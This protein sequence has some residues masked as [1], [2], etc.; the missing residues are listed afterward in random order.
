MLKLEEREIIKN[1]ITKGFDIKLISFELDIPLEEVKKCKLELEVMKKSALDMVNIKGNQNINKLD[2]IR[3]K[4]EE[5][6]FSNVENKANCLRALTDKEND[7]INSTFVELNKLLENINEIT[8]KEKYDR[9]NEIYNRIRMIENYPLTIEQ[10]EKLFSI[11]QTQS[12]SNLMRDRDQKRINKIKRIAVQK[13]ANAIDDIQL[14]TDELEELKKLK[15][16]LTQKMQQNN[17]IAVESIKTKIDAKITKINRQNAI[18][19]VRNNIP[20][21]IDFIIN[22]LAD[23]ELDIKKANEIIDEE[24][25]GR[26]ENEPKNKFSLTEEQERKQIFIQIRN[27]LIE[28]AKKYYIKNPET[29]IMQIHE[30]CGGELEE[31]IRAVAENLINTKDFERA[32]EVCSRFNGKSY[33]SS[34][35]VYIR[36]LRKNIQNAEIADIILKAI[37]MNGTEE[38]QKKCWDILEK[39]IEWRNV[40]LE[41][42]S[43]GKSQDGLRNITLADVWTDKTRNEKMK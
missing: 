32:K 28:K 30:L 40:N 19:R 5:L 6:Y 42:V 15:S 20:A 17:P 24:V 2:Q 38:E 26:M 14:Q 36:R 9:E 22:Q 27:G 3:R 34:L 35:S 23:G 8:K 21:N 13:L 12:F 37:K 18:D 39:G 4:Y 41:A 31:S 25:K 1:L 16:R 11:M 7:E 29:T 10:A 33:Q 43:L